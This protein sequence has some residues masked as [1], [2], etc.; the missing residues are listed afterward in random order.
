MVYDQETDTFSQVGARDLAFKIQMYWIKIGL[1]GS[2]VWIEPLQFR[3]LPHA[4]RETI[5]QVRSNLVERLRSGA[6][7]QTNRTQKDQKNVYGY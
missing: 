3:P 2:K 1:T 4:K 5:Y 6:E 7:G